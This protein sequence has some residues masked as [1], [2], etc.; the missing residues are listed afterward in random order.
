MGYL[1]ISSLRAELIDMVPGRN[2]GQR[3]QFKVLSVRFSPG[4]SGLKGNPIPGWKLGVS[5]GQGTSIVSI[6]G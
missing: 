5:S 2:L 3:M 1:A 4:P 6:G